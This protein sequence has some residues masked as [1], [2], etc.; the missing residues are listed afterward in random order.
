MCVF[1]F[2]HTMQIATLGRFHVYLAHKFV[3]GVAQ[4]GK[5]IHS[6]YKPLNPVFGQSSTDLSCSDPK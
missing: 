3:E 6:T 2:M 4:K 5:L 1:L